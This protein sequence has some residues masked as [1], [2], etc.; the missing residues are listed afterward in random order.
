MQRE[1]QQTSIEGPEN[2]IC[3]GWNHNGSLLGSLWKD[4]KYRIIDPR[5]NHFAIQADSHQGPKTQKFTYLDNNYIT[6]VGFSAHNSR[7][8][9]LWDLRKAEKRV[10]NIVIDTVSGTLYPYFDNDLNILYVWGQGNSNIRYYEFTEGQL[11]SLS[12]YS[13]KI[14][15]KSIGFYPKSVVNTQKCEVN[16]AIKLEDNKIT[17]INFIQ[18]RIRV[19]HKYISI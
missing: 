16:R 8:I 5:Q 3:L 14:P 10:Q 2:N 15:Q 4:K 13:S 12:N 17:L 18:P 6:T 7:E 9:A 11:Y 19:I 1:N